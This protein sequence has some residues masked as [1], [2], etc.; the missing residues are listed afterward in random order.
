MDVGIFKEAQ[1]AYARG[2]FD[3]ALDGFI[4]CTRSA[5]ELS[6]SDLSKFYHLIGNCY[7]KLGDPVDAASA[8]S[9]A[10]AG[11]SEKRKPSLYVNLGTALLGTKEYDKALTAFTR[12][13]DYPVYTTPYK[14][15]AGVG[16]AQL[17]LGNMTEAGAAYR[18]AALDPANPDPAKALVNLGV[19]FME[20]GRAGDAAKTYETALEFDLAPTARA[21]ALANLGQAYLAEGRVNKALS[22]FDEALSDD[23]YQLSP[24]ARHDYDI[25][26]TLK[27]KLDAR[28]PGVLDTGFI[29]KV[30]P[31]KAEEDKDKA[32]E[33]PTTM[34]LDKSGHLPVFGEPGF[35]PFAPRTIDPEQLKEKE[36]EPEEDSEKSA[37]GAS[38]EGESE[39]GA[40]E[41]SEGEAPEEEIPEE[42]PSEE[43]EPPEPESE[44]V[45]EEPVSE[46][47][48]EPEASAEA[49]E[50]RRVNDDGVDEEELEAALEELGIAT[51]D[52]RRAGASDSVEHE[53]ARQDA[54]ELGPDPDATM[55]LVPDE[56]S[57]AETV[58][59]PAV[60]PNSDLEI[61]TE[62]NPVI[63]ESED[64]AEDEQ[65]EPAESGEE[66][67]DKTDVLAHPVSTGIPDEELE[68]EG[69]T[70]DD[71]IIDSGEPL[72]DLDAT[73]THMPSPENT[74]FFDRTEEQIVEDARED[75]KKARKSRGVG[76]KV[77]I[78]IVVLAIL[79]VGAGA[80][81]YVL[82]YGYPMQEDIARDFFAAAQSGSDTSQYW[83]SDV[84]ESSQ[85]SQMAVL[86][87]LTSYNVEAVS[88]SMSQTTVYVKG[89]LSEGGQVDYELVMSRNGISWAIEYIELYFPSQDQ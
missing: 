7:V 35:D 50:P 28:M 47:S 19:C 68:V 49:A 30:E 84:D 25:A 41:A 62:E 66:D 77:A 26:L 33:G 48:E 70:F 88:R 20:L 78:L 52:D 10:L 69:Q 32:V 64:E 18:E 65:E 14:A 11:S 58:L 23:T 15:Y 74:E 83:A 80:V 38:D 4:E 39:E 54:D 76:L 17:K 29:P 42:E 82:G 27:E 2:D 57:T 9:Y 75:R 45:R 5:N 81:A 60:E 34:E 1:E 56:A 61:P 13:L 67:P 55:V 71:D 40:K 85:N 63:T 36:E 37:D 87:D 21:K 72:V 3:S 89:T 6:P 51:H 53:Q 46:E 8:Y 22:A 86:G 79:V 59:I 31:A 44:T 73:D 24:M 43:E 12:A 16:A